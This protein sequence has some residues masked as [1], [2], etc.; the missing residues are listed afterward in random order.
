MHGRMTIDMLQYS[1]EQPEDVPL[2][3]RSEHHHYEEVQARHVPGVV[4]ER[5]VQVGSSCM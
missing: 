5:G 4:Q 1:F 2:T 3:Q